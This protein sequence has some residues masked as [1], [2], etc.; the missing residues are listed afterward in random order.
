MQKFCI[1]KIKAKNLE[2]LQ[3]KQKEK[4]FNHIKK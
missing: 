2:K 3:V 4:Q 1:I